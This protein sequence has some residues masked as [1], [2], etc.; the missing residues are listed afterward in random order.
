MK[1]KS[2]LIATLLAFASAGMAQVTLTQTSTSDFMKGTGDNV[3]IADDN[4]SLY[5]LSYSLNL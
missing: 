2:L 4:I 5:Q 3:V 1:L